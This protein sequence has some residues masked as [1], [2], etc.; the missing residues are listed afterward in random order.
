MQCRATRAIKRRFGAKS[1]LDYLIGETLLTFAEV[2]R[3]HPTFAK[4]LPK[5]LAGIWQV[6]NEYEIAGYVA[7]RKPIAR[8]SPP[9]AYISALIA[10]GVAIPDRATAPASTEAVWS[11]RHLVDA[12]SVRA[13]R[14]S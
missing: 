12:R 5:F 10:R 9:S 11:G 13:R 1:A 8:K 6:F 14:A 7:S 4:E 3:Q 2:A